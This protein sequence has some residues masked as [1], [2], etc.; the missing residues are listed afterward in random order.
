VQ[1]IMAMQVLTDNERAAALELMPGWSLRTDGTAISRT[2]AFVDFSAA[3]GFMTQ[4]ALAAERQGHHPDWSNV[5]GRVDIT[6]TTHEAG[7]LTGRDV[8]LAKA[9]DRLV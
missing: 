4:V 7:G 3:F 2:F 6:L 1:E 8:A 5:Y 9:I